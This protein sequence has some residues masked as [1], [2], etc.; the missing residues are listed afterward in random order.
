MS[1][2]AVIAR[3]GG[4]GLGVAL[5]ATAGQ[6]RG[7]AEARLPAST[8]NREGDI[9][10]AQSAATPSAGAS[11]PTVVL[12]HGA[13]T[14]ASSWAG[15]IAALQAAGVAVLAPANPLRGP[16]SDAAYIASIVNQIPGPVVLAAHSYGGAVI[17]AAATQTPNVEALVYVAAFIPDEGES[18]QS[19]AGQA[20]DSKV[21]PALRPMQVTTRPGA[22][23]EVEFTIDP[24]AFPEVFA[25][26][27]PAA[28]AAVMAVSQRPL[29]GAGFTEAIGPVDWKNLPLWAVVS[30][31]DIVIGPSGE[32]LM[33]ERAKATIV[34]I[35]G[36]HVLMI[37]QP[38]A[39]ANVI[40]T[41][42]NA[43]GGTAATPTA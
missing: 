24:A 14:D 43:V 34:E 12:V 29:S 11:A 2:R 19:L 30:P 42:V 39:V 41:A 28:Q 23:S 22:P 6:T 35:D 1:R 20:T 21:G 4:A 25:A 32:R 17:S 26:D 18:L 13:F 10:M 36:S 8:A 38:Q 3:A 40:L 27:V 15:V 7:A 9:I 37:A 16:A 31:H 5:A 33:A